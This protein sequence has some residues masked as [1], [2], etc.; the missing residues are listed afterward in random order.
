VSCALLKNKMSIYLDV[1][2]CRNDKKSM[3]TMQYEV[4]SFIEML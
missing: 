2:F 1:Y 4:S 3:L